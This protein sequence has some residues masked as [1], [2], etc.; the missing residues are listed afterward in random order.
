M[1]PRYNWRRTGH[2]V[3]CC[4]E[5]TAFQR[6]TITERTSEPLPHAGKLIKD[7]GINYA[8]LMQFQRRKKQTS[9]PEWETLLKCFEW[10]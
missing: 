10:D 9:I 1:R 5:R 6:G 8:E 7:K 4:G 2:F 3:Q